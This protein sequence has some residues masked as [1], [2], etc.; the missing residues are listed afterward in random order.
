MQGSEKIREW[1]LI[2]GRGGRCLRV[3]GGDV[4]DFANRVRGKS[5]I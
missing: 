3:G 4:T 2:T 5:S 1:L